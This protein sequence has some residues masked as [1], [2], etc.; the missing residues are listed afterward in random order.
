MGDKI[1][2]RETAPERP[3]HAQ[4]TSE[5][6]CPDCGSPMAIRTAKSGKNTGSRFYG[7]TAYPP[8]K[9]PLPAE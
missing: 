2:P 8:C 1:S 3:R 9:T 6:T 5:K 7:C 4:K